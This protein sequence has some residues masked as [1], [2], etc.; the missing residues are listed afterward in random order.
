MENDI[1]TLAQAELETLSAEE[2]AL[3]PA[4]S[5]AILTGAAENSGSL[6]AEFGGMQPEADLEIEKTRDP[7]A[8]LPGTPFT[9]EITVT[10][11]GPAPVIPVAATDFLD[12]SLIDNLVDIALVDVDT[13]GI[14]VG[15]GGNLIPG[16]FG[17]NSI[18]DLILFMAPESSITY[19]V[20]VVI[21]CDVESGTEIINSAA[22]ETLPF[23]IDPPENNFDEDIATIES[24]GNING[25]ASTAF[26]T[27]GDDTIVGSAGNQFLFGLNGDDKI[28]GGAGIDQ[29]FGGF[30]DDS[31]VGGSGND[32][33]DG[34]NGED[35]LDGACTSLGIGQIDRLIGGADADLFILGN[36]TDS[37][38]LGNGD[39]DFAYIP[40]FATGTDML[41]LN[42][43]FEDYELMQTQVLL[44]NVNITGQGIF[45]DGDLV[46]LLQQSEAVE[47][48]ITFVGGII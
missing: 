35:T 24:S 14:V 1:L 44:Q 33:L 27:N 40:D 5:L 9:Y 39:L 18:T 48:D 23:F 10:N 41:V 19:T 3:I 34:Q 38:Y 11:N 47:T 12:A 46:A 45:Q 17:P 29:I 36:M 31:L 42:G 32:F 21:D 37:F 22:V 30:G 43:S 16:L 13:D 28:F 4:D 25:L 6:Q 8:I 26:G 2:L 20:E 15:A 7:E